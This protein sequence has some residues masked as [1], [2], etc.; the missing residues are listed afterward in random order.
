MKCWLED[1]LNEQCCCN[2]AW[3]FEDYLHC[4]TIEDRKDHGCVCNII[5]GYI[6]IPP[7]FEGRMHS[8]WPK[9]S[10]GCEMYTPKDKYTVQMQSKKLENTM[11]TAEYKDYLA[12]LEEQERRENEA[13]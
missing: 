6:C 5:K 2:C 12:S 11:T 1:E 9:H 7:E 3:H 10:C 8:G 13:E 4:N